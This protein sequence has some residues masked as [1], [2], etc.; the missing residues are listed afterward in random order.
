MF[1]RIRHLI[2]KEMIHVFRDKRLRITLIVPPMFQLIIFGYAANIDVKNIATAIRD[3]DKTVDSREL[4][5]R[6]A[7][8]KY[9]KIVEYLDG[10]DDI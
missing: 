9:F 5:S 2:I 8:S 4:I 10:Q 6:F 7:G 3:L 1:Y